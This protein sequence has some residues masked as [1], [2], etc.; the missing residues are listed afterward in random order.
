[1]TPV[2]V[3]ASLE[4]GAEGVGLLRTEFLY[5]ERSHLPDEDEQY[6]AYRAIVDAFGDMPVILR[7]LDIGGDKELPYL[8]LSREMNPFL[9]V[10][11]IRLCLSRPEL[12]KPQLR[13]AL[14]AG[15][16]RN[17]K[18]MFPMVSTVGEVRAARGLLE[19]CRAELLAEG[20]AVADEMEVGIMVE[21]PATAVMADR[22]AA[23]WPAMWRHFASRRH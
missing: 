9:G 12:F 22:L 11:A 6:Q 2:A 21:I 20:Q 13:A 3:Q 8:D 17:L 10:R 19:E 18:I 16:E 15:A 5:L 14:R 1:M 4:A 23:A 7:T